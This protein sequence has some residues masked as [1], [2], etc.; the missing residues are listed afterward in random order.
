M[1][2]SFRAEYRIVGGH[3]VLDLVNTVSPRLRGGDPERDYLTSPSELIAWARRIELIDLRDYSAVEGTWRSAP[4]L[5]AK[6]L[7]ATLEIREAAYD[8][9]APRSA[10]AVIA[11]D[12]VKHSEGSAFERLMLR[13]SA[14]AARSMLIPDADR[15]RG[16]AEL[17]VGTSPAQLIPD[18]LVVAAVELVRGVELRQLRACPVDDGGCGWLFLDRSRNGSRRW[19]AMEDCGTRA[20]IRKLGARRRATGVQ[21]L[22]G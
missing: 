14:A 21:Q 1:T 4:E 19:C 11:G 7:N 8:V 22:Q 6:A 20:K 12:G 18:R 17:V 10:G 13:W 5:A 2:D 3:P 9:F 15:E 16:I